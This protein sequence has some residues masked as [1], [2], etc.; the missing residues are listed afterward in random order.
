MTLKFKCF[1]IFANLNSRPT[2][3]TLLFLDQANVAV[4]QKARNEP[5]LI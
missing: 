5:E 3:Q 1:T 2:T 4:E